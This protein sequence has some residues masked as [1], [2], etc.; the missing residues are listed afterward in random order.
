MWRWFGP[1]LFTRSSVRSSTWF[2]SGPE[3]SSGFGRVMRETPRKKRKAPSPRVTARTVRWLV[4][5]RRA[6]MA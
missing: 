4:M 3:S 2:A 1:P 5:R 6:S